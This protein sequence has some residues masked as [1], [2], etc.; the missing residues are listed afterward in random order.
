MAWS[1]LFKGIGL[2][3]ALVKAGKGLETATAVEQA[4]INVPNLQKGAAFSNALNS[5]AQKYVKQP[6]ASILKDS[7]RILTST[8]GTFG[9]ASIEGL[10]RMNQFRDKAIQDYIDKTGFRPIGKDLEEINDYTDKI[11]MYT[12]GFNT[13]LLTGTNYISLP[14]ILGSSRKAEKALINDI[15]QSGVGKEFKAVLPSTKFGRILQNTKGVSKVLFAKSE[16]FEEGM[17]NAIQTGVGDYFARA[18]ENKSEVDDFLGNLNGAMGNVLGEGI[19]VTLSTK[20]G[21]ESILIGGLSG[22]IQ[23]AKGTIK[24][25]GLFGTGGI[26]SINTKSAIDALNQTNIAKVLQ[27]GSNF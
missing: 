7:D 15:T 2:T 4:M 17:Q 12:W 24:E 22:G 18:Y 21:L 3:N 16:A 10:Q 5:I 8:M 9:E 6:I 13:L 26:K 11:G 19:D 23:Q 14:K 20:E 1:S 27:D 25:Q